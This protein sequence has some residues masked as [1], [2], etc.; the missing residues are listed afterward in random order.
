MGSTISKLF[1]P[2][3]FTPLPVT[4]FTTLIYAALLTSLL[5]VHTVVPSAP[6][7]PVPFKGINISEAWLDLQVLTDGFHPYN[8]RRN[9]EIRDWL[10]RRVENIIDENQ[11]Q[12]TIED[13]RMN[14]CELSGSSVLD[15]RSKGHHGLPM[16]HTHQ[17]LCENDGVSAEAI[18]YNDLISNVTFSSG[19]GLTSSGRPR[20][21][22]QSVYFE[23]TNIIVY[24]R[25]S[26]DYPSLPNSTV[27]EPRRTTGGVLV[28]AHYDSVSTGFGATDDGVGVITA[29]QLI[30]YYT[31]PGNAPRKGLVI[32]LNNGEEDFLNG[33]RAFTRHPISEFPHTF[34]NLEGTGA[35]G[36]AT[37]FRSTDMEV[38]RFYARSPYP[39][40][41]VLSADGFK[42]GLVRSQ[43]DYIVFNG[44]LGLRGLDVAF[45][46][47]RA[48]YH[49]DQDDARHSAS[50]RNVL[51]IQH[52]G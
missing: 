45:I 2:F 4:I 48:R 25:G 38:T 40:G 42:R 29:L 5:V 11:R 3:N 20:N 19:G 12:S 22:G 41:S 24:I 35:G 16:L 15:L 52:I 7:N 6:K 47:P 34:L 32:L 36:R 10:L 49:T 18:I 46:E 37:L 51:G 44:I 14:R 27:I 30:R 31:T 26:E 50:K 8:S 39:F 21:D 28:N 9:D 23:G 13:G 33:A 17:E 1:R 43:T